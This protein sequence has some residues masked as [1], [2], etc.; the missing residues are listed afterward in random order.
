MLNSAGAPVIDVEGRFTGENYL[1]GDY[2]I[3]SPRSQKEA[4]DFKILRR[5][6]LYWILIE[7]LLK[8]SDLKI[9]CTARLNCLKFH[10]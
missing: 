3:D 1:T 2:R 4:V 6:I 10:A 5:E 9:F 8:L 7:T